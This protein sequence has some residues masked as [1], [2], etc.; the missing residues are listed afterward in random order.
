M[1]ETES[2]RL[3]Y[4]ASQMRAL[5]SDA[6]PK[7]ALDRIRLFHFDLARSLI[8][9]S[10]ERTDETRFPCGVVGC[11]ADGGTTAA[12]GSS[13]SSSSENCTAASSSNSLPSSEA[14]E[15]LPARDNEEDKADSADEDR[16]K[17][18]ALSARDKAENARSN[19]EI[20][21]FSLVRG[22]PA[23]V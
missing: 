5:L 9:R 3:T 23:G 14:N 6:G 13:V 20:P 16:E 17:D 18:K 15:M 21:L 7:S 8:R 11:G 2:A 4:A 10:W 19:P 12:A 22:D 1:S